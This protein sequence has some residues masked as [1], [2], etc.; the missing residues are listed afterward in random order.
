MKKSL[1]IIIVL[2]TLQTGSFAQKIDYK[3]IDFYYLEHLIKIGIDSLRK[4]KGLQQLY[5]DSILYLAAKDQSDYILYTN[6]FGH[7]QLNNPIK[8][9]PHK[10][11][12]YYGGDYP[13]TAENV[14]KIF[15]YIPVKS[16]VHNGKSVQIQDYKQAAQEFVIGWRNSKG[17]YKNIIHPDFNITGIS[18]SYNSKTQALYAVQTFGKTDRKLDNQAIKSSV[19]K[20]ENNSA[21]IVPKPHKKHAWG[22]K[23][24]DNIKNKE[25][26]QKLKQMYLSDLKLLVRND[27]IYIQFSSLNSSRLFFQDK[28]DGLTLEFIP[29]KHYTS[30]S[31]YYT[32]HS[33]RNGACIFNGFVKKPLYKKEL[34]DLIKQ[35]R[36]LRKSQSLIIN[37]GK[38]PEY[39]QN[40]LSEINL[41]VLDKNQ[42]IDNISFK[43]LQ[44][45][46]LFYQVKADTIPVKFQVRDSEFSYKPDYD[47]LIYK[48]HFERDETNTDYSEL[49]KMLQQIDQKRYKP[50]YGIV[51][52]FASV[53][54]AVDHNIELYQQRAQNMIN[55]IKSELKDSF[56]LFINTKENWALFHK[57]INNTKYEFLSDTSIEYIRRF[58]SLNQPLIDLDKELK[59]QRYVNLYLVLKEVITEKTYINYAINDYY[60]TFKTANEK[61]S[62]SNMDKK[63]LSNLQHYIFNKVLE[64]KIGWHTLDTLPISFNLGKYNSTK[65]SFRQLEIDF[66]M[67]NLAYN[68]KLTDK[69][70]YLYY[71][72]LANINGTDPIVSL[73]Y[74]IM[75]I[76]KRYSKI[77]TYI[78]F[79]D[80]KVLSHFKKTLDKFDKTDTI[81][82]IKDLKLYYHI[83]NLF[84]VYKLNPFSNLSNNKNSIRFIYDYFMDS[85]LDENIR[86]RAAQ[87]LILF[88]SY[89]LAFNL[90]KDLYD[91]GTDNKEIITSYLILKYSN[92]NITDDFYLLFLLAEEFSSEDW[93]NLFTGSNRINFQILDYEIMRDFY[94]KQC[95]CE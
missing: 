12:T 34:Y 25:R 89:D 55:V 5:N 91:N 65:Q 68:K 83:E 10:R 8:E 21:Y 32:R 40:E 45:N 11:I 59:Q 38:V 51:T 41:L 43:H 84:Q 53:E 85:S 72:Q 76:D 93:C 7:Y 39:I 13:T 58:L 66:M 18:V 69:T 80:M 49:K 75:S 67:F 44:G 79:S 78:D 64:G 48:V 95:G 94:C 24:G 50:Y 33:R 62:L 70:K 15:L 61:Y 22:I 30:D 6:N 16:N 1:L 86:I 17:H 73:N 77:A 71:K 35:Q 82:L 57:Q 63:K 36:K 14:A 37:F 20:P 31:I 4:E 52:S 54:G 46:L 2:V 9:T 87:Y 23:S 3:N 42:I 74:F 81:K 90:I 92:N 27:S 29:F 26:Y 28:K 47:T 19:L 56:Q 88:E 60:R